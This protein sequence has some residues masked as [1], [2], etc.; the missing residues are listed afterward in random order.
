MYQIRHGNLLLSHTE[1]M[2][3][4][5]DREFMKNEFIGS[6]V[7]VK[8]CSDP[9]WVGTQG[10]ILDETKH[11]FLLEIGNQQ[12]RIAKEIA[13]FEFIR[14]KEKIIVDGTR[15]CYRPEDRIKKAR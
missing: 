11:T 13:I 10:V 6:T 1:L 8:A 2:S 12:K 7:T 5:T 14:D 15:L 4:N 3:M 9:V